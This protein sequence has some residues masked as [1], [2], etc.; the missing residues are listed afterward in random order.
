MCATQTSSTLAPTSELHL[1]QKMLAF[2]TTTIVHV[3][4]TKVAWQIFALFFL[5]SSSMAK[6]PPP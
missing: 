4:G 5:C 1:K 2:A 3:H 6:P